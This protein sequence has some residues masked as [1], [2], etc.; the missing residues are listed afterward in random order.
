MV[1]SW[2]RKDTEVESR[3]NSAQEA[4]MPGVTLAPWLVLGLSSVL[5]FLAGC[6][7]SSDC[8][9]ALFTATARQAP[10]SFPLPT[11]PHP[12]LGVAQGTWCNL[13]LQGSVC[14][15]RRSEVGERL[16]PDCDLGQ[17][18]TPLCLHIFICQKK[19]IVAVGARRIAVMSKCENARKA[20]RVVPC[21]Q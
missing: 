11:P 9:P 7:Q 12:P 3:E 5:Y 21:T 6:P 15:R 4:M 18:F 16:T 10:G 1:F 8:L 13:Q 14:P 20:L 17:D 2:L 19:C